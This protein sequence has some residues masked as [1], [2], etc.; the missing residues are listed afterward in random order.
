VLGTLETV[1]SHRML[2]RLIRGRLWIGIVAF[3]LI[4]IVTLQL[5]LLKLN[6]G[7]GRSLQRESMLQ[8]E[9]AALS[10]E[11]SELAAG[12]RVESQAQGLGMRLLPTGGPRFLA[13][14]PHGDVSRAAQ[15]LQARKPVEASGEAAAAG[16]AASATQ[17]TA[18]T[19]GTAEEPSAAGAKQPSEATAETPAHTEAQT[20]GGEAHATPAAHEP[21]AGEGRTGASAAEGGATEASA[22]PTSAEGGTAAPGG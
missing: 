3:A 13:S 18:S 15:A 1:S 11:N 7:I 22:P 4:G 20:G 9:N 5:G 6:S 10:I 14:D 12:A 17:T 2:D 21:V 16:T 8:R 19:G